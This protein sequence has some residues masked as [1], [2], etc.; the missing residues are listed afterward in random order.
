MTKY[1]IIRSIVNDLG[2]QDYR[3]GQITDA[4]FKRGISRYDDMAQLPKELRRALTE[5][6]GENVCGFTADLHRVAKQT[7]KTLFLLKDGNAT[8]TVALRYRRGWNSFC[9]SSQCGCACG[10]KFCAT[11][12]MGFKRN[13]TAD[14]ITDQLLFFMQSGR[15]LDSVSFMGM[16]EP[17]L[18][19]EVFT[20]ISDL[21]NPELFGLS[22]RRITLS[23]V[24]I[25]SGIRQM[26]ERFPSVNLAFS[27]HAPSDGLRRTIMP[28]NDRY[29]IA[30]VFAALDD[31]IMSTNRRVFLA[32]VMLDGVNDG[33]GTARELVALINSHKRCKQL[34]RVDLIP[35]NAT[36]NG[37]FKPSKKSRI[38]AFCDMLRRNGISVSV[39]TQFGSDVNAACGQLA[40]GK[41]L[42][43]S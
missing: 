26:T 19:P 20:A 15:S 10:C 22:Q 7:D 35:Y 2:Y 6:L 12:G 18:N 5:R 42:M 41:T 11:G 33:E 30:D 24:G 39:R 36:P 14:E 16:G 32:Y 8:E 21:T 13:L 38:A 9:I 23:T 40:V 28:V 37:K 31:H 43:P 1:E 25:V 27:L 17:L 29:C 4:I 34:Y 3:F